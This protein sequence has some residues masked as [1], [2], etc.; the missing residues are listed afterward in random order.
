V[1]AD[2]KAGTRDV[3][4]AMLASGLARPYNGG[5]RYQPQCAG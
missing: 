1:L 2:M 4:A 5:K 3:A